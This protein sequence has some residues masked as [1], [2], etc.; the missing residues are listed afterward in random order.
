MPCLQL[1]VWMRIII[2]IL[3]QKILQMH[4]KIFLQKSISKKKKTAKLFMNI[5][6]TNWNTHL[7]SLTRDLLRLWTPWLLI[8]LAT[9]LP[10]I[11]V[12][13]IWQKLKWI[14]TQEWTFKIWLKIN[15]QMFQQA[16]NHLC[17]QSSL[18]KFMLKLLLTWIKLKVAISSST[19]QKLAKTALMKK[20]WTKAIRCLK[21]LHCLCKI[22][23]AHLTQKML[24]FKSWA[25]LSTLHLTA[26]QQAKTL[27]FKLNLQKV[28]CNFL[29]SM[30]L[31]QASS[32]KILLTKWVLK[33]F[34]KQWLAIMTMVTL[35]WLTA[36]A[37]LLTM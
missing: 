27:K 10:W 37:I 19:I 8:I 21:L 22:W 9:N 3:R 7:C 28:A 11:F 32:T 18:K 17:F 5:L 25:M 36:M 26:L 35:I 13:L 12:N 30:M 20:L 31:W 24:L 6:K 1:L 34:N 23:M 2:K 29:Q 14:F 16:C 33:K 15:L 4:C